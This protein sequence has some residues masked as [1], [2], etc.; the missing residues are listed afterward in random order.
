MRQVIIAS[1]AGNAYHMEEEGY[2]ALRQYLDRA[3]AGLQNNPDVEEILCDVERSLASKCTATLRPD[4]NVVSF[5]EMTAILEAMG[6]IVEEASIPREE[7]RASEPEGPRRLYRQPNGAVIEGVCMGLSEYF[8]IDVVFIR[9]IF[10]VLAMVSG[11]FGT[12]L[13]FVMIV[14][15]PSRE[16]KKPKV[17][18][19]IKVHPAILV[20][21]GVLFIIAFAVA[22]PWFTVPGMNWHFSMR[23]FGIAALAGL[24]L[25]L[26]L[27]AGFIALAFVLLRNMFVKD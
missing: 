5:E 11:G 19:R 27:A 8:N 23:P 4:K 22:I 10:V 18:R 20:A 21:A 2:A 24:L 16:P 17:R 25:K 26:G 12:L 14:A 7:P 15:V 1:L 3:K 9:I 6:P 13:Y